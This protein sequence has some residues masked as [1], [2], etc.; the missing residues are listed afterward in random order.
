[1]AEVTD[2]TEIT[3]VK[4][5][6]MRVFQVTASDGETFST[7]GFQTITYASATYKADPA[8]GNP[9]GC[10]ISGSVVTIECTGASDVVMLL[11]VSGY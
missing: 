7:S 4:N 11:S 2:I 5:P 10:T 8:T 6:G 3:T 1:M 9:I